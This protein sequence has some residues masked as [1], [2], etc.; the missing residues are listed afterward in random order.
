MKKVIVNCSAFPDEEK[1]LHIDEGI[2]NFKL[3][4]DVVMFKDEVLIVW[5]LL[6]PIAHGYGDLVQYMDRC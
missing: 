3:L 5:I 1:S 2:D 4:K 6:P